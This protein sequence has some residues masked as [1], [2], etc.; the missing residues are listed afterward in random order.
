M[1]F[2]ESDGCL[3]HPFNHMR[4]ELCQN[5]GKSSAFLETEYHNVS[6]VGMFIW[7]LSMY[8]VFNYRSEH[9]IPGD[10][11]QHCFQRRSITSALASSHFFSLPNA[12]IVGT[13]SFR[14]GL[15]Y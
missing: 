9:V 6:E 14:S 2:A 7:F 11:F 10:Y 5:K 8:V 3:I 15:T 4:R 1:C 12:S 13:T